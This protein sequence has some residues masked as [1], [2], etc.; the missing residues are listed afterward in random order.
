MRKI[1]ENPNEKNTLSQTNAI[2][3]YMRDGNAITPLEALNKFGAMRLSAI[4][5]KIEKRVGYPPLRRYVEVEGRDAEGRPTK[6]RV[7][8]YWLPDE[9]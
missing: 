3:Q 4:I 7:M 2:L 6:K 9:S 1:N 8:R 5:M